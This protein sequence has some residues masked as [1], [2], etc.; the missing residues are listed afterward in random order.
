MDTESTIN[1]FRTI[2]RSARRF[3][4]KTALVSHEDQRLSYAELDRL[5]NRFARGLSALGFSKGDH[6]GTLS[7]NANE[8]LIAF[9]GILKIGAVAVTV[10]VR[11]ADPEILWLLDHSDVAALVFDSDFKDRVDALRPDLPRLKHLIMFGGE[12]SPGVSAFEAILESGSDQESGVVVE[13]EDTAF[14]IYTS[15]TTGRPKGVMVTHNGFLWNCVNWSCAGSFRECDVALQVFPLFHVAAIGSV[16]THLYLGA[17]IHIKKSF[18]PRDYMETIA[19]ERIN[20]LAAAP[21]VFAMLLALPEIET[22]DTSSV[23]LIG[24]GSAIMPTEIQR[25][26]QAVFPAA[27]LFDTYGMSEASGGITTLQTEDFHRKTACVGRPHLNLEMRVVDDDDHDVSVGQVGEVIF[28]GNN[29]MKGYY[30]DPENTKSAIRDGWYHTGDM[31][32][33]DEEGFLYIVDRKKDMVITG[34]ENVY[35]REVEEVLY[36]HPGIAEAAVIGVPDAKWGEA[37]KAVIVLRPGHSAAPE[38]IIAFCR[39]HIAGYKCPKS[40]VF[41]EAL[42]KNPIGKVLK[43]TLKEQY[44]RS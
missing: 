32:R 12:P 4:D 19:R 34:G 31:G 41:V 37:V 28:R 6:I 29:R 14:I 8:L 40:V 39:K 5:S 35:P 9:F 33:L 23:E 24:S 25:R 13:G 43:R 38:E 44:D 1:L 17:T 22:Y 26:L 7:F 3:G 10:N 15:G 21:T 36:T 42:P 2:S 20:R 18:D 30:K 27:R 16:L 11:L